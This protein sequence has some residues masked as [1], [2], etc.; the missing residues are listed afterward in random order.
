MVTPPDHPPLA[1]L[2]H[3]V[4]THIPVKIHTYI[5]IYVYTRDLILLMPEE[6]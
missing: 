4:R 6:S 3:P 5:Y 2:N 1:L